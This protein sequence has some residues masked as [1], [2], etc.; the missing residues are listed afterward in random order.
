VLVPVV[1]VGHVGVSV[2]HRLVGVPVGVALRDR[3]PVVA[4]LMVLV[5]L[6][7]VLVDDRG[8]GMLVLVT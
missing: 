2:N 4:V 5:V 6:M 7:L 8:M 3:L 1:Q